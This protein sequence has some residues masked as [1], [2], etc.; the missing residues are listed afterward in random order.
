MKLKIT[1][2]LLLIVQLTFG[3]DRVKRI[4]SLLNAM[5]AQQKINGNF[6]IAEKGTVIYQKS[7]GLANEETKEPLNENSIFELASVSKQFTA[8]AIAILQEKGKL[9]LNDKMSKFIP[10]LA[11]YDHITIKNLVHHTSGLPDYM[12]LMET[13]FDKS[14]IATNKDIIAL[15]A[16]EQPKLLFDTNTKWEYSNTGYALL[17][18]IIEK[19]SGMSYGDYLQKAIFTPLKMTNTFVYTRR[20]APKKVSN[21]AYGYVYS[22]ELKKHVLPDDLAETKVVVWLDGIVGDGTVNSTANDLLIWDRAL[23][24]NQLLPKSG[25]EQIFTAGTLADGSA[26]KYGFGWMLDNHP[27]FGKTASHSGGWPGYKTHIDRHLDNDKTII[28][29]SNHEEATLP[30]NSLRSILYN[31]PLPVKKERKEITLTN[32]QLQKFVGVY[33]LMPGFEITISTDKDQLF[34]QPTG[35]SMLPIFAETETQFFLK[36]VDAQIQF[37]PNETGAITGLV[38]LQNGNKIEG[39]RIK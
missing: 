5:Y 26:T 22:N 7:F 12:E 18:T 23:Y 2:A 17:A 27:D 21:Y 24:T 34:A 19:A 15:F 8:M 30:I 20:Y 4:D 33:E 29:L 35:Q 6:L 31:K 11:F 16:K 10:E 32:E 1:I 25:M 36:V 37:V 3:Q 28:I 9:N 13:R 39:K 38:L 14:K